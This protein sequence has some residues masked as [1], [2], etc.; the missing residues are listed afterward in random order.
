[1]A[2]DFKALATGVGANVV[3]QGQY[4]TLLA[5]ALSDGFEAGLAK[6][7]EFNKVLRQCSSIAAALAQL[8]ADETGLDMLDDGD[9]ATLQSRFAAM[10]S[11]ISSVGVWSTGDIKLTMKNSADSGWIMM[12][13]QTI[14]DA[15]S[16]AA[17]ANDDA[18]D[19]FLLLWT[20][21]SNT[22]APV[23]G[24]RGANAAADWAAHKRITLTR[25]LGRMLGISGAG[26]GLSS[27]AL[28][29][30]LG[31]ETATI[32]T[33]NMPSHN[34]GITDPGHTHGITDPGH[35]HSYNG[36]TILSVGFQT[37]QPSASN[38]QSLNTDV[39]TTGITVNSAT[40]GI[41]TQNN[42][43]GT[44]FAI[45]NPVSYMNAMIKL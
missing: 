8:A 43:S 21:V 38:A 31:A 11:A 44:A 39:K 22:W 33:S 12:Q 5:G 4:E 16:G 30:F 23:V 2:N 1:M 34:H 41:T 27:R 15:A 37:P 10:I 19:L 17:F 14:G 9:L 28:G 26:S 45:M 42:G 40:T 32:T 29:E 36:I 35:F 3:T 13:D 6:S 7:S 24:G 18:E 25:T 20:N